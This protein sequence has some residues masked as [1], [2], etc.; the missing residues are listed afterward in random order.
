MIVEG[1]IA[2]LTLEDCVHMLLYHTAALNKIKLN[3]KI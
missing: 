1:S 2:C 3:N